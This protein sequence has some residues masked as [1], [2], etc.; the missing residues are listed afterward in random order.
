MEKEI[1]NLRKEHEKDLDCITALTEEIDRLKEQLQNQKL[2]ELQSKK[3]ELEK[4]IDEENYRIFMNMPR[5]PLEKEEKEEPKTKSL[6]EILME[7]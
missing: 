5:K 1:E 7:D 4:Q 6:D 2:N 3:Q